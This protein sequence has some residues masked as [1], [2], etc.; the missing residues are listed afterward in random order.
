MTNPVRS[1]LPVLCLVTVILTIVL[2]VPIGSATSAPFPNPVFTS[3]LSTPEPREFT[4]P[5][6]KTESWPVFNGVGHTLRVP[7]HWTAQPRQTQGGVRDGATFEL[8]WPDKQ[9]LAA[10]IEI[11]E[12]V[13]RESG[14]AAMA[15]ELSVMFLNS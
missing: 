15:S 13:N 7:P 8:T 1:S 9:G 3:P 12:I 11:L 10:R 4:L 14:A 5:T 2:T 6:A